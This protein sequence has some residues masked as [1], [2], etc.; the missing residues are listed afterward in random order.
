V[1]RKARQMPPLR[2][3]AVAVHDHSNVLGQAAT[4]EL[5]QQASF[6]LVCGFQAFRDLHDSL[7]GAPQARRPVIIL[8][9]A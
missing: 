9:A 7:S 2:P 4:I 8:N 3:T 5:A 1:T 6:F